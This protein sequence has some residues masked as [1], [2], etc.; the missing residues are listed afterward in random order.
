MRVIDDNFDNLNNFSFENINMINV[1]IYKKHIFDVVGAIHEVHKELWPGLNEY[2]YQE[3]LAM[4][5]VALLELMVKPNN[6]YKLNVLSLLSM[7]SLTNKE[8]VV[9]NKKF[10]TL[11]KRCKCSPRKSVKTFGL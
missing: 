2:C 10:P 3:G 9:N 1:D 7:L 4:Q 5:L 11:M 8:V 6:I